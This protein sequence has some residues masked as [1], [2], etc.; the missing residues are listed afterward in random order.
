MFQMLL[1]DIRVSFLRTRAELFLHEVPKVCVLHEVRD[2]HRAFYREKAA[3]DRCENFLNEGPYAG[4]RPILVA[5]LDAE[6][7]ANELSLDRVVRL[8]NVVAI[9]DEP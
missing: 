5:V 6:F 1:P 2:R 7:F 8:K 9:S 4:F 3:V